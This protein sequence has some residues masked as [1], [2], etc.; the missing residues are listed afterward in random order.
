MLY[1]FRILIAGDNYRSCSGNYSSVIY[2][3]EL[4]HLPY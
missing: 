2:L 1:F 4:L 3:I